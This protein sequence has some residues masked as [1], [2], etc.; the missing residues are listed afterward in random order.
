MMKKLLPLFVTGLILLSGFL[1]KA[2]KPVHMQINDF[3]QKIP[4]P[5]NSEGCYAACT[6]STDASGFITVKDNGAVF[7]GLQDQLTKMLN[8]DMAAMRSAA[9]TPPASTASSTASSSA[10]RAALMK[11]IGNAQNAAMQ[12]SAITRELGAKMAAIPAMATVHSGPNCPEVQQGSYAGPTCACEREH[13]IDYESRS[14]AARDELLKQMSDLIRQYIPKMREQVAIIDK[15]ESDANYGDGI[16]DPTTVQL[17][18]SMQRQ[19]MS[20]IPAI[21]GAASSTWTDGAKQY[22]SLVNARNKKCK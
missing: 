13:A 3:L 20:A 1:L 15:L 21:L 11:E 5:V 8:V 2:Q 19:G 17:L 7:N 14:V 18:W 6:T 16:G 4:L 12:I 22:A 9:G 10:N